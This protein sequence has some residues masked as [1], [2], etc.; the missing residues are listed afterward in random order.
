M[1]DGEITAMAILL[2]GLLAAEAE[3]A[4]SHQ[5]RRTCFDPVP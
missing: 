2:S 1:S 4:V 5:R 3:A